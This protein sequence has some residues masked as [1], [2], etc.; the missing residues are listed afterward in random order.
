MKKSMLFLF[1]AVLIA[2]AGVARAE[3]AARAD[4]VIPAEGVE[5]FEA[6]HPHDRFLGCV[7][8]AHECEHVA[9]SQGYH[10]HYTTYD[11]HRCGHHH[12]AC[13]GQQ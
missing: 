9:H 8:D 13:W 12:V 2:G 6:A 5:A 3:Q 11:H 1:A 10:H 7:H 4:V